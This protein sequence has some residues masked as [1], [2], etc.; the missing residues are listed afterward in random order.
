M[1]WQTLT[2]PRGC[3]LLRILQMCPFPVDDFLGFPYLYALAKLSIVLVCLANEILQNLHFPVYFC[4]LVCVLL[5]VHD[6]SPP[7]RILRL[8]PGPLRG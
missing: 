2:A 5:I 4:E 1:I 6:A 7:T 8:Y 3:L